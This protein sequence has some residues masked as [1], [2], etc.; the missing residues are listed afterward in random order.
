MAIG[1][2]EVI[3]AGER[4]SRVR[5]WVIVFA[6]ALAVVTYIDR[7]CISQ[8][9]KYI[10]RDLGLS[11]VQMGYVFAAFA[12]AYAMFEV[13]S[14]F[15][16]D[17][18]GARRVLMRI[19]VWWSFFTAATGW[20]WNF[21]SLT[22]TRFLFGAGEA[23]CFPNLT[24]AFTVWLPQNERV[25]AQGIM[26]PSARWGGA[27]TPFL[28]VMVFKWVSWRHAFEIFGG[29][30]LIW[31]VAFYFWFRDNPRDKKG[32][33]AGEL[34]LL[35]GNEELGAGH[36]NVPWKKLMRS[37][38]V[39]ML[40]LQYAF[41]SYGWYFY[42]TWLP[43]YLQ[44][45]RNLTITSGAIMAGLPLFLGGL[46]S[47]FCGF[48]SQPLTRLTGSVAKTRRLLACIGFAG[49][50]GL[51]VLSTFV[52]DPFLA[53]LAMGF[54]SFSND[55]VM[56]GSWGACMDVGGKYAGTLS[57]AMNM[58][59]NFGGALSPMAIGHM[60]KWTN[61]NWDVTFY[62]SA[63]VYS[64]GIICWL[65]LDPVTPIEAGDGK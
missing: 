15:L 16:G 18:M 57:G 51:L 12:W 26:W 35:R 2:P 59:G 5:Y 9:E 63:L 54:A 22:V 45:S 8:A 48:I 4:P 36:A 13:P 39:W 38:Q 40:C 47:L 61:N 27:F 17:W 33:N 32:V 3:Q 25:R 55:L 30:G 29:L 31:A 21:T 52:R 34:A 14:G 11:R 23:G 24:K 1:T 20:A 64:L 58:A 7:V 62:V 44:E 19:V 56:P 50:S 28:V 60:L 6:V 37:R 53:M 65:F 10:V 42:I 41:L 49:A 46:G 43:T